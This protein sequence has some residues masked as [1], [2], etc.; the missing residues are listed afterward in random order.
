M[1]SFV[2]LTLVLA[3]TMVHCSTTVKPLTNKLVIKRSSLTR[4]NLSLMKNIMGSIRTQSKRR[5]QAVESTMTLTPDVGT[6]LK[7]TGPIKIDGMTGD[8][9][10]QLGF[11]IMRSIGTT[12]NFSWTQAPTQFAKMK[13]IA[14]AP[15]N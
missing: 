7:A 2:A 10:F 6:K 5:T 15:I 11:P 9:G 14:F 1:K 3:I 12:L 4:R 13:I 8:W